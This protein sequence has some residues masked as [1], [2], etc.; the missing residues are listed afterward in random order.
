MIRAILTDI[1]GTTTSIAFVHDILFPYAR[2]HLS[3]FIQENQDDESVQQWLEVARAESG[4]PGLSVQD[5]ITLLL[6]WIA[7]DRKSTPLKALQ[8][9][10]WEKG[11]REGAYQGHLYPD[12]PDCLK[13]W[14][15]LGIALY[16]F[17]SGSVKAQQLLFAHTAYGDLTPLFKGYFDTTTGPKQNQNSYQLIAKAINQAPTDVL[18]LSD[19]SAELNA[20]LAAGMQTCRLVREGAM[21]KNCGHPQVRSF[22]DIGVNPDSLIQTFSD[23]SVLE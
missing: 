2:Q 1:E 15:Q 20:A 21:E 9:M 12:V 13:H 8:G 6:Q 14:Q 23:S 22:A 17:S 11:Y 5:T 10:L 19:I 4:Q 16:V 3:A 7:E 18:F